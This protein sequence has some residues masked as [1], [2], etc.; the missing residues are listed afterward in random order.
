MNDIERA[1]KLISTG[2]M[3]GDDELVRMGEE[4]LEKITG[5]P[6]EEVQEKKYFCSN[7][8]KE[9]SVDKDRKRCIYCK[10]QKLKIIEEN[11]PNDDAG[12]DNEEESYIAKIK[13]EGKERDRRIFNEDGTVKGTV[14]KKVPLNIN[15]KAIDE[16]EYKDDPVNEVIKKISKPIT[17]HRPKYRE[18]K[19]TCTGCYKD[20]HVNPSLVSE[21][22]RYQC[23]KCL[24]GRTRRNAM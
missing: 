14:G 21:R 22:D 7:C 17:S 24:L 2:M 5:P 23:D 12:N 11:I 19:V 3:L 4:M 20:Y 1:K 10:K 18:I 8:E 6:K 9:F 16:G 15:I 13:V